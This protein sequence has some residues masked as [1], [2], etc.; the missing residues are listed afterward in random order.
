MIEI[1]SKVEA[2]QKALDLIIEIQLKAMRTALRSI[3]LFSD[4]EAYGP[5]DEQRAELERLQAEI[6]EPI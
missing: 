4:M 3:S 1:S 6:Q 5:L 2:R